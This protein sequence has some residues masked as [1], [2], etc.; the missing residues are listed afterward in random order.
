MS[1]QLIDL[2]NQVRQRCDQTNSNYATDDEVN[3]YINHSY[4]ELYDLLTDTYEEYY[5]TDGYIISVSSGNTITLPSDFYKLRGVD[6]SVDG[7]AGNWMSITNFNFEERDKYTQTSLVG[8]YWTNTVKYKLIGTNSLKLYPANNANGTYQ[9]WYIPR[10]IN[11]VNDSDTVSDL[12]NWH[13]YVVIDAAIKIMVKEESDPTMLLA[14]KADMRARI[15]TAASNRDVG[16][17]ER[18][19]DVHSSWRRW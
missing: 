8:I 9:I 4:A 16:E 15:Q 6:R 3:T 13:E 7:S 2:R 10:F 19:G 18:I 1:V 11:L 5:T 12:Q 17:Q 14:A